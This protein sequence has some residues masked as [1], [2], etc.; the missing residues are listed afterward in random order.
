MSKNGSPAFM[1]IFVSRSN[2]DS[3]IKA[4]KILKFPKRQTEPQ[5][6]IFTEIKR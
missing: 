1:N 3:Q 6:R 4:I 2:L 5:D